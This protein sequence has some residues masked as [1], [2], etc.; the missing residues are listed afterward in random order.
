MVPMQDS[1]L[2]SPCWDR[3]PSRESQLIAGWLG[4]VADLPVGSLVTGVPGQLQ[5]GGA[6]PGSAL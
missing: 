4:K 2:E 3:W 6:L 1:H 5:E